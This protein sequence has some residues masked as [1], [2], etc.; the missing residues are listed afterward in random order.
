MSR[1]RRAILAATTV[2][3]ALAASLPGDVHARALVARVVRVV[4]GDTLEVRSGH[5]ELTLRL[6]YIDAPEHD[7][8]YGREARRSLEQLVRLDRVRVET[9]GRDRFGRT[10]ARVIRESD[11]L[12]VN[13]AQ[14]ERGFA[15]S[16]ARGDTRA[17]IERAE[18]AARQARL[19]LWADPRPVSPRTWRRAR[20][21]RR[22]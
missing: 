20:S 1:M 16:Y 5:R 2:I 15:W 12:D 21:P 10:L 4:D 18:R 8:P 17:E 14:V 3:A 19:G 11:S 6:L 9:R 13:L 22:P 7:Q